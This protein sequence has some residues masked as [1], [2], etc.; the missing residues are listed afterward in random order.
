MAQ[1]LEHLYAVTKDGRRC[2]L[3]GLTRW[4]VEN[5]STAAQQDAPDEA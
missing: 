2:V 1:T 3:T 5:S 4:Q